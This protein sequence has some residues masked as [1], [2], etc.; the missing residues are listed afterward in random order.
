MLTLLLTLLSPAQADAWSC[1]AWC[2]A[3][4]LAGCP[5]RIRVYGEGSTIKKE[6][7]SWRVLGVWWLDCDTGAA[8]DAGATVVLDHP[9]DAG[10][11]LRQASPAAAVRC[12]SQSCALPAG[13]CVTESSGLFQ[14]I[15]CTD[16]QA[17]SAAEL[18]R[19]TAAP[20]TAP[21]TAPSTAA[22]VPLPVLSGHITVDVRLPDAPTDACQSSASVQEESRKRVSLGDVARLHGELDEAVQE[23][24]V[25][26]TLDRCSAYAWAALGQVMLQGSR[27]IEAIRALQIATTLNPQHYS[28]FTALGEALERMG[29]LD[30]AAIAY[31]QALG[32]QPGHLPASQGLA[33]VQADLHGELTGPQLRQ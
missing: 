16:G 23:Y 20:A 14:L 28:A 22:V 6:G 33:R 4:G 10:E 32:V 12:F 7:A 2:R 3:D 26:L 11:I 19:T 21:A 24:L 29:Q 5:T 25:A 30:R 13:A 17:L 15:R 31:T 9:P 27:P 8:F 1:Q 18:A